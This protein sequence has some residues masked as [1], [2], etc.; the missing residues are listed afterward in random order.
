MTSGKC[1]CGKLTWEFSGEP[2]AAYHCH[3]S[4][5]RKA[6]GAAFGTY[7]YVKA[8]HFRWTGSLDTLTQY[9]S[10]PDLDRPFCRECGSMVPGSD[11]DNVYV[12][13]PAGSHGDGPSIAEHIM[14]GSKAPWYDI[15]D[16]L[17]QYDTYPPEQDATVYPDKP[18]PPRVEGVI[19]GSCL[20]GVV[21]FQVTEPFKVIHN[22][23][24]SRCRRARAA[25]FTTN[26]FVSS[27]GIRFLSGEEHISVFKLPD[28]KYFTHA[29]CDICGSGLPRV[30]A[31]RKIAVIPLGSLDDDPGAKPV[32]HIF[33]SNKADW[34]EICDDLPVYEEMPGR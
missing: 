9:S 28:A 30:D 4:M 24:C 26:G 1:L 6:H 8:E 15:A 11:K 29:F 2:E 3:C 5:C 14:V 34:F 20:C 22:C 18:L 19:R 23:H 16:K 31:R 27:E 13:V 10:S 25:A 7:Y 21:E 33:A 17:P 12:F 32:D